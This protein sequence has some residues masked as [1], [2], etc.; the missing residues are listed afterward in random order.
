MSRRRSG[1]DWPKKTEGGETK[2]KENA[3]QK[4][5]NVEQKKKGS[6]RPKRKGDARLRK[7]GN[8]KSKKNGGRRKK[9]AFAD[10]SLSGTLWLGNRRKTGEFNSSSDEDW[11][12]M[13]GGGRKQKL[14]LPELRPRSKQRKRSNRES[15]RSGG[16]PL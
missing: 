15:S 13:I 2:K 8:A 7:K 11:L 1:T 12:K 14:P 6:V 9:S 4:T 5:G 3:R 16:P 10:S